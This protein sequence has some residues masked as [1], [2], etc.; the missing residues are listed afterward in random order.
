M[1]ETRAKVLII[2]HCERIKSP[3]PVYMALMSDADQATAFA[4]RASGKT[5]AA[6]AACIKEYD[7]KQIVANRKMALEYC[8]PATAQ[9]DGGFGGRV[10]FNIC[11][12]RHDMLQAMCKQQLDFQVAMEHRKDPW[13]QHANQGCPLGNI[14]MSPADVAAL[15][16]APPVPAMAPL[17][18]K[19]FA[20]PDVVIPPRPA[21]PIPA[22]TV[23]EVKLQGS[24]NGNNI[25]DMSLSPAY[26]PANL[27]K[28]LIVGGQTVLPVNAIFHLR[29]RMIGQ[30]DAL[31]RPD[32]VKI[33]IS[34][35]EIGVDKIDQFG[36]PQCPCGKHA[37]VTSNELVFTVSYVLNA[38]K[39]SV[40]FDTIL[41]FTIGGSG[42]TEAPTE[43]PAVGGRRG[44]APPVPA[45]PAPT[46]A[47][48]PAAPDPQQRAEEARK[49]NE[50]IQA[51]VQEAIRNNPGGGI[52]LTLAV[53][54]CTQAK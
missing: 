18:A 42:S 21:L 1:S 46:S 36:Q 16:A 49:R 8:Y 33:G 47:A 29:A 45:A 27:V 50:R 31:V 14:P 26:I 6:V 40:R 12:H 13:K 4:D 7:A 54:A 34:M 44:A 5:K 24:W 17:P 43:Q 35:D 20:P 11:L 53:S 19:F 3:Y 25:D 52:P 51:C 15:K 41:R 22:G 28:P 2:N 32:L 10:T 39:P 48:P 30:D 37:D 38:N 23:V 9:E